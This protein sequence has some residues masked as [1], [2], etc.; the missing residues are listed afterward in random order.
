MICAGIPPVM[1]AVLEH[2]LRSFRR[3]F[4][5]IRTWQLPKFTWEKSVILKQYD[6][7]ITCTGNQSMAGQG[8]YPRSGYLKAPQQAMGN[9]LADAVQRACTKINDCIGFMNKI[10]LRIFNFR[11]MMRECR[12]NKKGSVNTI[13]QQCATSTHVFKTW[14]IRSQQ[15]LK[16][17]NCSRILWWSDIEQ[18]LDLFT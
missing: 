5:G 8:I 9:A 15:A 10:S 14:G 3:S 17:S 18:H 2:R 12:H 13:N 11:I 6:G 16:G 1:P 4:Y 7:S